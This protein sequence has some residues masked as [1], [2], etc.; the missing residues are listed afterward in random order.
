MYFALP[1]SE[2]MRQIENSEINDSLEFQRDFVWTKNK[3]QDL[4]TTYQNKK[5]FGIV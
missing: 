3:Q 2:I 5:G 4:I 1:L